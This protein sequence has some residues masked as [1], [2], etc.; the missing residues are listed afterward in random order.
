[1]CQDE[2]VAPAPLIDEKPLKPAKAVVK[3][4]LMKRDVTILPQ[5]EDA[6]NN[7]SLK[8]FKTFRK[9]QPMI[10]NGAASVV[11]HA[12]TTTNRTTGSTVSFMLVYY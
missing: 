5:V 4:L 10:H 6:H 12:T 8:N 11:S 7:K 1:M 3:P 2:N 9:V